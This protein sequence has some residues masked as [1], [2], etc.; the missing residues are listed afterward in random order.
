MQHWRVLEFEEAFQLH[1]VA[2]VTNLDQQQEAPIPLL[3]AAD[4]AIEFGR[5]E[6]IGWQ[7]QVETKA[8][9]LQTV[10][11]TMLEVH[12]DPIWNSKL[13]V[14]EGLQAQQALELEL[15]DSVI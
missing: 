1:E 2:Q 6:E 5:L 9:E 10:L 12:Q 11:L 14:G 7:K 15:E 13:A 4:M 8:E 3:V